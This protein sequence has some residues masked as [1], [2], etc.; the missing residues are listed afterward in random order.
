MR[1]LV[2]SPISTTAIGGPAYVTRSLVEQLQQSGNEALATCPTRLEMRTFPLFRQILIFFRA[3]S[4]SRSFENLILLDVTSTGLPFGLAA[5]LLGKRVVVRVGGDFLW[6][7]YVERT[8][9]AVLL[10]EFYSERRTLSLY[11]TMIKWATRTTLHL[12]D[13]IVFTTPWL[14]QIWEAP[15]SLEQ[16]S[17]HIISN[18][19]PSRDLQPPPEKKVFLSSGRPMRIKNIEMLKNTVWPQIQKEYPEAVLDTEPKKHEEYKE[20]LKSAYAVILP[21]LSD[22]SP[23]SILE[24]ISYGKPFICTKDTG[25]FETYKEAGI[26]VNTQNT[27]EMVFAIRTLLTP[28]GYAEAKSQVD[29]VVYPRDDKTLAEQYLEILIP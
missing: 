17:I 21:S 26:F 22:V 18:P 16:K 25:L 13:D 24:A 19:L 7:S 3:V 20:A 8:G 15:Y 6:E 5:R 23:N 9:K 1:I 2:V 28:E 29:A 11:E 27:E 10:S 12:A 4:V 14:K